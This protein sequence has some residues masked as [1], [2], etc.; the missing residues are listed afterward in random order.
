MH[1]SFV[2]QELIIHAFLTQEQVAQLRGGKVVSVSDIIEDEASAGAGM[3]PEALEPQDVEEVED[4]GLAMGGVILDQPLIMSMITEGV[5]RVT[6]VG[7]EVA[8]ITFTTPFQGDVILPSHLSLLDPARSYT[9]RMLQ[10][11]LARCVTAYTASVC[12]HFAFS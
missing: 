10:P 5:L 6:F 4:V 2:A 1:E 9:A 12:L 11:A 3:R 8:E 7:Q